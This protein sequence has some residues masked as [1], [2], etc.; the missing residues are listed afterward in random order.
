MESVTVVHVHSRP[1]ADHDQRPGVQASPPLRLGLPNHPWGTT[2]KQYL[3]AAAVALA[4]VGS[5]VAQPAFA[6]SAEPV[7][8]RSEERREGKECVRTCRARWWPAQ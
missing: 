3:L 6:Q 4:T 8:L 5:A 1:A 2:L 7:D